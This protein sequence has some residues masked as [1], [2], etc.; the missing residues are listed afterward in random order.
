[1]PLACPARSKEVPRIYQK[2]CRRVERIVHVTQVTSVGPN[3]VQ[4]TMEGMLV[5]KGVASG[6]TLL[7]TEDCTR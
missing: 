7:K 1:M 4:E 3:G 6:E 5:T 2:P